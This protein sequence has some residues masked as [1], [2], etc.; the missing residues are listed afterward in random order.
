MAGAGAKRMEAREEADLRVL[1]WRV[2]GLAPRLGQAV[3][4]GA[5]V[6]L[7]TRSVLAFVWLALCMAREAAQAA[8]RAKSSFL[9]VTSHAIRTPLNGVLGMAQAMAN[10][11]LS[12]V[13]RDRVDVIR[14]A[15]EALLDILNDIL[16]LSKIEAG[17]LDLETAP[18][19]LEA[20]TRSAVGA[21][22]ASALAKG[23]D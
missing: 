18:F 10:D 23:L 19:D 2:D 5:L 1:R 16:D 11:E 8:S 22:S 12:E 3:L 4:I 15:G 6:W 20:V 13:Q 14:Q 21:F 17:K 9:A 7:Q